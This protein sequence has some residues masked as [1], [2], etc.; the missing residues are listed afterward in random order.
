MDSGLL[1]IVFLQEVP[2]FH[3][4]IR[5]IAINS[6]YPKTFSVFFKLV[7]KRDS[8][9]RKLMLSIN[10]ICMLFKSYIDNGKVRDL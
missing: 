9:L 2:F 7:N 5:K 8:K 6:S 4:W 1:I 3:K 10:C